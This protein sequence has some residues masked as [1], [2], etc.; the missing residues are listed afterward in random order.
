MSPPVGPPTH[1][2][3]VIRV[4]EAEHVVATHRAAL[5][6]AASWGVPAHVTVLFPF[7]DPAAFDEE[8]RARLRAALVDIPAFGAVFARTAWFGDEVLYLAPE[9]DE[10][11]RALT[12]A[13]AAAFP[14]HLPYGGVHDEV[15]PHLTVGHAVPVQ[16]LRAA[17]REV[18]S[19]LPIRTSVTGVDVI[20]GRPVPGGRWSVVAAFPLAGA[21]PTG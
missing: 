15:V 18:V 19:A 14:D 6:E 4:A 17:E 16:Y 21:G 13:V 1:S 3:V 2:A 11:F 5:D 12:L 8:H 9:P 7:V 20:V 10:P